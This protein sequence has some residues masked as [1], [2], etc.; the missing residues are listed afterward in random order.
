M[1]DGTPPFDVNGASQ[2]GSRLRPVLG[3]C[4]TLFLQLHNSPSFSHLVVYNRCDVHRKPQKRKS[5]L[6]P[7]EVAEI[8]MVSPTTV[9]QWSTEGKLP[10]LATPGGHRRF[11]RAD[12]YQ[13]SRDRGLKL[14]IPSSNDE[15]RIL[16]VHNNIDVI[17][18]LTRFFERLNS[19]VDT[20][21][22]TNGYDAGRLV[23]NFQ[24]HIVFLKL[25]MP[26]MDGFE[27][28][29]TIKSD[30]V[31]A[32]IRVIGM[33]GFDDDVNVEKI[34]SAGAEICLAKPF[35]EASLLEAIGMDAN[36]LRTVEEDAES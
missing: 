30:P 12:I 19:L 24:P 14:H 4:R 34:I 18:F 13:F 31:S 21:I 17:S 26:G 3:R 23:N 20:K 35:T 32:S 15:L 1:P 33:T 11:L 8:L 9:R 28:C 10:S 36:A 16:I 22:A 29:K 6:T 25:M 2:A 5:Y 27:V 7:N